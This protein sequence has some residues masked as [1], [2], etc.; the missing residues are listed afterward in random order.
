MAFF[1]I[2]VENSKVN[3]TRVL[4]VGTSFAEYLMHD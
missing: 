4:P 1:G 3:K 2:T